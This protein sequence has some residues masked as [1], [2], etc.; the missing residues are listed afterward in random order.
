M[1]DAE[2]LQPLGCNPPASVKKDIRG[3]KSFRNRRN[4]QL[5]ISFDRN[6]EHESSA[7]RSTAGRRPKRFAGN[8]PCNGL[9][10]VVGNIA[11]PIM[12]ARHER[13][14][15]VSTFPVN[16]V[17]TGESVN[18]MSTEKGAMICGTSHA[19]PRETNLVTVSHN[20]MVGRFTIPVESKSV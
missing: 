3:N 14:H 7:F 6:F 11:P 19:I 9:S 2:G 13:W 17:F 5:N 10:A 12:R 20:F 1:I 4:I 18:G 16:S 8:M 15:R